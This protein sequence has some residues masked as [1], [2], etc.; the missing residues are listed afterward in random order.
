M[1]NPKRHVQQGQQRHR[2]SALTQGHVRVENGLHAQFRHDAN[3]RRLAAHVG[4]QHGIHCR[5]TDSGS[6]QCGY[7]GDHAVDDH[8]HAMLHAAQECARHACDLKAADLRQY[9]DGIVGIRLVDFKCAGDR[10]P[11]ADEPGV[12][13]ACA[14]SGQFLGG[15]AQ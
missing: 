13:Q 6:D 5:R 15:T 11:L 9:G 8:R 10:L 1:V 4:G 2:A 14:A 12:G 3:H 7:S